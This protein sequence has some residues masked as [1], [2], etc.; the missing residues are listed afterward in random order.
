MPFAAPLLHIIPGTTGF[1]EDI[2]VIG[3]AVILVVVFTFA[4][5]KWGRF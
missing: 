3:G 2:L 1:L 5:N 4:W